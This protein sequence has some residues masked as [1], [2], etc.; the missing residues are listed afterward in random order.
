[1]QEKKTSRSHQE[2]SESTRAALIA[3]ARQL[4][5]E[6]GYASTSTPDIA[7]AAK[8]T[9]GALYHHFEDKAELFLAVAQQ[10]AQE[11]ARAIETSSVYTKSP[12]DALLEGSKAYFKAMAEHGR[13]QLLLQDAPA[14]LNTQQLSQLS[15][16]A[17][18]YALEEGLGAL[19]M[20]TDSRASISSEELHALAQLISAAF[21]RTAQAL[22]QKQNIAYHQAALYK[23]L[24]GLCNVYAK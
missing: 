1:M 21:D 18:A 11:V 13:A 5:V 15:D 10:M 4:F 24:Q 6:R 8:V 23:L 14:V 16:M 17:G 22:A 9:R 19:L 3:A 7:D 2:R 20:G 12:M